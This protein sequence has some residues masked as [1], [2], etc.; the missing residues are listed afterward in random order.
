MPKSPA[1]TCC[2]TSRLN[3]FSRD[4]VM[5]PDLSFSHECENVQVNS[6]IFVYL[7]SYIKIYQGEELPHPKS[8]LQVGI[9]D[10]RKTRSPK[11]FFS[12]HTAKE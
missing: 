11:S 8:M 2:I 4:L 6:V 12:P 5:I 3:K 9:V 10:A 7:Q 1:G